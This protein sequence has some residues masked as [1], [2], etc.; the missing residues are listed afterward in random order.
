M[1][2]SRLRLVSQTVLVAQRFLDLVVDLLDRKLL[3]YLK[4]PAAGFFR[5]TLQDLLAVRV[6]LLPPGRIAATSATHARTTED[7]STNAAICIW[8]RKQNGIHQSI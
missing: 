2:S 1:P 8:I 4:E 6:L 3:R 5:K 7:A